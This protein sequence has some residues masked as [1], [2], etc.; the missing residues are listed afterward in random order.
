MLVK[1][2]M[3]REKCFYSECLAANTETFEIGAEVGKVNSIDGH[4]ELAIWIRDHIGL[5]LL[6]DPG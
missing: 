2:T 5:D 6:K 4:I 3:H 1:V